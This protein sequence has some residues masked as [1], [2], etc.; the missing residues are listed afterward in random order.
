MNAHDAEA[1]AETIG[2]SREVVLVKAIIHEGDSASVL[3]EDGLTGDTFRISSAEDWADRI[4][5]AARSG[6]FGDG[7]AWADHPP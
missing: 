3:L 6:F 4:R 5:T 7:A 2:H 1:L